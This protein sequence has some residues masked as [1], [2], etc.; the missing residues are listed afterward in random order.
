MLTLVFLTI[1]SGATNAK[2][3]NV[4]RSVDDVVTAR[5]LAE[6]SANPAADFAEI[7]N[8]AS[9]S[10]Q[11]RSRAVLALSQFADEATQK[12]IALYASDATPALRLAATKVLARW[13][14]R[15]QF[16]LSVDAIAAMDRSLTDEDEA[17]QLQAVRALS[18]VSTAAHPAA[19]STL[20]KA[21]R[22]SKN[23]LLRDEIARSLARSRR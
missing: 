11:I 14:S 8:D 23:E 15:P 20:F 12:Q 2:L 13:A 10:L 19:R 6:M 5:E 21:F 1:F 9:L 22:A 17:V 16:A 4:L 3:V 18:L 7:A